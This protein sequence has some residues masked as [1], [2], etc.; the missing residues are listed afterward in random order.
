MFYNT[1]DNYE[2]NDCVSKGACS[3]SPAISSM[4]EIMFVLL[5]QMAYYLIKLKGFG[6]IKEE[7]TKTLISQV[8]LMD[9]LKDF[10]EAQVL[11]IFSSQYSKL[12]ELRKEYL[13]ICK[14]HEEQCRI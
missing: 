10:T 5:R 8:A 13:K 2:Y 14:D 6:I 9:G 7:I 4:Q 3:I 1:S 12:I 11:N